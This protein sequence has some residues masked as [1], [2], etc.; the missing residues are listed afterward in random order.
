MRKCCAQLKRHMGTKAL[1]VIC[2]GHV[3]KRPAYAPMGPKVQEEMALHPTENKD[4][5]LNVFLLEDCDSYIA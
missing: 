1:E 4:K 5:G 3:N 2:M